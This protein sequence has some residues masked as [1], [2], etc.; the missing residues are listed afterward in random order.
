M[1]ET[2][3]HPQIRRA[4]PLD[5][6]SIASVLKQA[7]AEYEPL[8]TRAGYAATTPDADGV[9]TRMEEG[10][11]WVA[12]YN[13]EILATASAVSKP[14]GVYVR[15]MAA[16]PA[17]RGLG[18][19]RLLLVEIERFA[20][21]HGYKRLF[22]STTPF[23]ARA[24]RLYESF[25]FQRSSDGPQELFGTPLFTMEKLLQEALFTQERYPH[26]AS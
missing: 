21:T 10:P 6:T 7:F 19:G 4:T 2:T 15:G 17:S 22:L 8:Y 14:A 24:I 1:K 3:S 18:V 20:A 5:V 13:E 26:V 16:L 12:L 11:V 9:R 23:L 25:G